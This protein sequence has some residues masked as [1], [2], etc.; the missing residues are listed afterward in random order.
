[1][2]RRTFE[3]DAQKCLRDILSELQFLRLAGVDVSTP[4]DAGSTITGVADW[5]RLSQSA[6]RYMHRGIEA[7]AGIRIA[8]VDTRTT[9]ASF[10]GEMLITH[11][12]G[13]RLVPVRHALQIKKN[14][15]RGELFLT[16]GLGHSRLLQ[17]NALL[18]K[19]LHFAGADNRIKVL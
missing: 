10:Q 17:D 15:P 9:L 1:M 12:R 18:A 16:E 5:L 6:R 4:A 14:Y 7:F 19:I 2:A 11:D 3:V 13:D 8:E